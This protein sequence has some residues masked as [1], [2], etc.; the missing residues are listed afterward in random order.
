ME[1]CTRENGIQKPAKE[2]VEAFKFGQMVL[3]TMVFGK[4]EWPVV[5]ADSFTLKEMST[6]ERGTRIKRT[7]LEF[8][9]TIMA[10]DTKVN[11]LTTSN[12][13]MESKSGLMAPST[14]AS[15]LKE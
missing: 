15:M 3:A 9:L 10:A 13:A 2:M 5:M 7:D 11:G 4:T 12:M 1:P 14:K 8:I 6:K